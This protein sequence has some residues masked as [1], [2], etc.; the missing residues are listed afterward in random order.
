MHLITY[1]SIDFLYILINIILSYIKE[2]IMCGE[3]D[4][5]KN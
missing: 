4:I 2:G 5:W 1:F 3:G